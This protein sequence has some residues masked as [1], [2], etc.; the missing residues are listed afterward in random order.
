MEVEALAVPADQP[1]VAGRVEAAELAVGDH[2]VDHDVGAAR[3]GP[4]HPA[5]PGLRHQV[6][7]GRH[8]AQL[9]L[10]AV[11]VDRRQEPVTVGVDD[12]DAGLDE[13]ADLGDTSGAVVEVQD[14]VVPPRHVDDVLHR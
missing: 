5:E 12:P 2:V 9:A 8:A 14:T 7:V 11:L 6:R 1:G 10:R 13:L 4:G 3:G